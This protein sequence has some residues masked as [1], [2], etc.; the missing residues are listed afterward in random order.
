MADS[1]FRNVNGTCSDASQEHTFSIVG[2]SG[3]VVG[4]C[5]SSNP[6]K[7]DQSSISWLNFWHWGVFLLMRINQMLP[8][9]FRNG[10]FHNCMKIIGRNEWGLLVGSVASLQ[11]RRP[12][13][14]FLDL[15]DVNE[16]FYSGHHPVGQIYFVFHH[17]PQLVLAHHF[18]IHIECCRNRAVIWQFAVFSRVVQLVKALAIP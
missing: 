17:S 13:F 12:H 10:H 2:S 15:L 1:P 16:G 4:T 8:S 7:S 14:V 11:E 18:H 3:T 5:W 9:K 6:L